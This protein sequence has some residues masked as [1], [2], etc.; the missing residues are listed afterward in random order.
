MITRK[1]G[2]YKTKHCN[3]ATASVS[4]NVGGEG[5]GPNLTVNA[6]CLATCEAKQFYHWLG[7]AVAWMEEQEQGQRQ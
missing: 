2:S 4:A 6:D 3:Y 7:N 5:S 1:P